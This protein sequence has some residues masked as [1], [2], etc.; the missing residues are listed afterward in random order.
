M[1]GNENCRYC[2]R[3]CVVVA[4]AA[5]GLG[6]GTLQIAFPI[7]APEDGYRRYKI[8]TPTVKAP[9][10]AGVEIK[11]TKNSEA[12]PFDKIKF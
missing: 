5:L 8:D 4:N 12:S 9:E 11:T 2:R 6:D 10:V 7:D 1:D 3:C